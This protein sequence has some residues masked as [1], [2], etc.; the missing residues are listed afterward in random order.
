MGRGEIVDINET[1]EATA[2][3]AA[4]ET[5]LL[6]KTENLL[7]NKRN[8]FQKTEVLLYNYK[9]FKNIISEKDKQIK[10]IKRDGL[11]KKSK[12][13]TSWGG[14][15]NQEPESDMEKM[16]NKIAE[17]EKSIAVTR[18]LMEVID[19]ALEKIV[20]DPY[21]EMI[22]MFYFKGAGRDAIAEYFECDTV[23]VYR[24]KKR[25]VDMLKMDL[26]SDDAITEIF[27]S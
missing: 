1:I 5:V 26:F 17:I 15:T 10:L 25:I 24:N 21:Y 8:A 19:A 14:N 11:P 20:N 12:S 16:E 9:K 13:I 3:A 23:T 4:S 18:R 7:K 2:K 22:E 27:Y 6:L